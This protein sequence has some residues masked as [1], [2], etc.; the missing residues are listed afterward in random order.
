[1]ETIERRVSGLMAACARADTPELL[2]E[3]VSQRL[4]TIVPF[5]GAGWFATDPSTVLATLPVRIENIEPGDC[6]TF[7]ERE[8]RVEDALLF[9]DLARSE[10][11]VGTLYAATDDHPLRSA[12]YREFL[13]PQG[14]GDELRGVCR[15]GENVWGVLDLYRERSRTP[16]SRADLE[17]LRAVAPAMALA[18]RTFVSRAQVPAGSAAGTGPGTAL[19]DANGSLLSL[20]EQAERLLTEAAGPDWASL[21]YSMTPVRAVVARAMA[22]QAGTDRGPATAR[23]RAASGRWLALHAS[24]LRGADGGAGPVALTI[25][26]AKSA[27]LAPIIVEAYALT[28]REQEITRAVARGLSNPEIAAELFLSP[29]TVRDHLKAIFAKVGV[30]SRGELVAKLFAEHYGPSLHSA[31]AP[32]QHVSF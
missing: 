13:A 5:D 25:E 23:I 28:P 10:S 19:Y 4:R 11:G 20:D 12:R 31:S 24:Y 14:Y 8:C 22:I 27:Q 16:F 32:V 21:P 26:P 17:V 7:W 1:M 6:E 15:L 30:G 29:H 3:Q 18:L 9:R 2:F